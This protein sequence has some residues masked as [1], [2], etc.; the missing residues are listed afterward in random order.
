[1]D[2]TH[3]FY[4]WAGYKRHS[5]NGA[6]PHDLGKEDF[7]EAAMRMFVGIAHGGGEAHLLFAK[8]SRGEIPV[9]IVTVTE[10]NFYAWPHVVWFP[11]ATSRHRI[12]CTVHYLCELKK[13]MPAMII[14][15]KQDV[16]FFRHVCKYGV[17]R[18][19]GKADALN[20]QIFE[21]V[22]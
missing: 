16:P 21:T 11:E 5:F 6:F 17:L 18:P 10:F 2:E 7:F 20:S 4:L 14:P 9:G 13:V 1:M 3:R 12:E 19:V 15:E 22:G 8:T